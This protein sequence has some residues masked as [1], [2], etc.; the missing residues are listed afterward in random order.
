MLVPRGALLE[1]TSLSAGGATVLDVERLT[2]CAAGRANRVPGGQES[3]VCT[4]PRVSWHR[5]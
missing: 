5:W 1:E 4:R 3:R 2:G